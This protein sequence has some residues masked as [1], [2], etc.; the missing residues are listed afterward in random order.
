MKHYTYGIST[1]NITT[2]IDDN[3]SS[4]KI[5]DYLGSGTGIT[6]V[7]GDN[8]LKPEPL[9]KEEMEKIVYIL[10]ALKLASVSEEELKTLMRRWLQIEDSK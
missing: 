5:Q 9:T 4:F 8:F 1:D 7:W 10:K 3:Q 6:P 2:P